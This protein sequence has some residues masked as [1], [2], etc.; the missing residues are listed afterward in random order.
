M[1]ITNNE[2]ADI[3]RKIATRIVSTGADENGLLHITAQ[4][5]RAIL[6]A[7]MLVDDQNQ[8]YV[9]KLR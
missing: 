4:E 1:I 7:S 5:M 2:N 6:W 8:V 9:I 3:I